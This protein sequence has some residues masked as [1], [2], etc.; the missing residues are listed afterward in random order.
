MLKTRKQVGESDM[1]HAQADEPTRQKPL[2]LWPGV[3]IVALQLLARFVVPA[4][5][6]E[7][8]LYGI[9]GGVFVG[10]LAI[11]V[12][13]VFF[14]RA[15]WSERLGAIVLMV[16]AVLVTPL[17]LHVSIETGGMGMLFIILVIPSLSVAL[18]VGAVASRRLSDGPRRVTLAMTILLACGVWTLLRTG[19]ATRR[20]R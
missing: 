19:G 6:P 13:W 10:G 4:F 8:A 3:V 5:S 9:M 7:A 16:V 2:R 11:V 17:F 18:V 14:S 12:W 1:A 20:I 15:L